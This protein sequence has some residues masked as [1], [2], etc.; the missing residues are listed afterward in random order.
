[1]KRKIKLLGFI[2][3]SDRKTEPIKAGII[4]TSSV[5]E[6]PAF[7]CFNGA[8]ADNPIHLTL[9]EWSCLQKSFMQFSWIGLA[10]FQDGMD[11]TKTLA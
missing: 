6:R 10:D 2:L 1:M 7:L 5:L 4:N 11:F 8:L 3:L 9:P